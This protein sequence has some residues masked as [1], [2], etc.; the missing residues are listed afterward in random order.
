MQKNDVKQGRDLVTAVFSKIALHSDDKIPKSHAL[1]SQL[2]YTQPLAGR[3]AK[4]HA[5][6][7]AKDNYRKTPLNPTFLSFTP[8]PTCLSF[9]SCP[10]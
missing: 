2:M 3:A 9:E 5:V 1:S 4:S 10:E 7:E 8:T 6:T